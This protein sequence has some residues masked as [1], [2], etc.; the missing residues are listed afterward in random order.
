MNA[1]SQIASGQSIGRRERQEDRVAVARLR[2]GKDVR[3]FVLADG[4]GGHARGD[5]A[6]AL[7]TKAFLGSLETNPSALDQALSAA[8]ASIHDA[9]ASDSALNGM[10]STIVGVLVAGTALRWISVG[11][12]PLMLLRGGRLH[13]LN[14]DHSMREILAGMVAS[15]RLSADDAAR[16]PRRNALRS[17]VSGDTIEL[18]DAPG[19]AVPLEDGDV[20]LLASDGIETLAPEEIARIA[21]AA[22]S[23]GARRIVGRLLAAVDSR[24]SK[25]QDNTSIVVYVH[26]AGR[27]RSPARNMGIAAVVAALGL[28]LALGSGLV[29]LSPWKDVAMQR[30]DSSKDHG[31]ARH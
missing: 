5:V 27:D 18:I 29:W 21:Q 9:A 25:Y 20:V 17:A 10:G 6:A 16:D 15:G 26:A 23:G 2:T 13:R 22:L 4:M 11:D 7:A 3:A 14:A 19:E 30:H 12:S 28:A 1:R 24:Q 8:N 31:H